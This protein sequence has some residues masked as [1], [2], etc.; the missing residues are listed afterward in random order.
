MK[1]GT[2]SRARCQ[3]DFFFSTSSIRIGCFTMIPTTLSA[4]PKGEDRNV[5][6]NVVVQEALRMRIAFD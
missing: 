4:R 2:D 1:S 5:Y 6:H 3:M